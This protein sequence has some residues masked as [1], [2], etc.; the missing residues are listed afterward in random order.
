[1]DTPQIHAAARARGVTEQGLDQVTAKVLA[2]FA[3]SAPPPAEVEAYID[4]L[5]VWDKLGMDK[6]TFDSMPVTW[7]RT[8]G[9]VYQP[10]V[11]VHSRRPVTRDLTPE[12]LA[13]LQAQGLDRY[14]YITRARALQQT[15]RPQ[16]VERN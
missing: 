3:G 11:P 14:T 6:A 15:P 9:Q 5:Y 12:E 2:R 16:Q 4:G 7:R 13:A 10:P 1:V 8:Q